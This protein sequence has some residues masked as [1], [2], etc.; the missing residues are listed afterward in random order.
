VAVGDGTAT[1]YTVTHNLGSK[2]VT[3][4]VVEVATNEVVIAD[5][6]MPTAN[7]VAV[8]FDTA[9]TANQ[10]RVTVIG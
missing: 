6:T 3:V 8:A 1:S 10:Y 9:A 4:S 5:V 7:T 2:D